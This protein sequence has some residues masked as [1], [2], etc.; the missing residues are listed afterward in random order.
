VVIG[1][2]AAAVALVVG[3]AGWWYRQVTADPRLEF[4]GPNMYR[5]E[6]ATD[7]SGI[8]TDDSRHGIDEVDTVRVAFVPNGR[9]YAFF[10]L[11]NGGG[12]DVHIEAAPAAR[13]YYWGFDRM[14]LSSDRNTGFGGRYEPFRSFTLHRGETRYVRLEFRLAGCDPAAF[15]PGGFSTLRGLHVSYRI[16]GISRS[17]D[18]PFQ[19]AAIAL[20]ASG[21]CT[22]PIV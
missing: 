10:G 11:S 16:L 13:M 2:A 5:D 7:H 18:V 19:D 9:L 4:S 20:Q 17:A 21:V 14:S 22:H 6:A 3:A 15:Q 1:A 12:H 8:V